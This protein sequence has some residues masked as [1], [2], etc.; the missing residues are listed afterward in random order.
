MS[1]EISKIFDYYQE[2]INEAIFSLLANKI[3]SGLA[4]LGIVIGIASVIIMLSLGQS[5]QKSIQSQ[6]Q[7]LGSNLL[8]ISPGATTSSGVRQAA[9]SSNTLILDDALA[10]K[11]KFLNNYITDVSPELSRRAQV[12]YERNNTNTQ[13]VGVYPGYQILRNIG[14]SEGDFISQFDVDGIKQVAVLGPQVVSDLFGDGVDPVGKTIRITGKSFRVIGVTTSKGGTGFFNQDD[15]IFVPLSTAQKILFGVDYLSSIAI[16]IKDEKLMNQARDEIGYF[17]LAR[18]KINNPYQADFTIMSQADILQT[19]TSVTSTFTNLLSGI[20][21]ISLLVGGIGIMNIMLVS[22][23]ERTREIGL[24][25]A[26]GAKNKIVVLQFLTESIILT[27]IGGIIGIISGVII[28][29]VLAKLMN[30]SFVLSWWGI[31]LSFI[32]SSIVG[33]VFGFYPAKKASELSPIEAL[34]YE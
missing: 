3:R 16:G 11:S 25:K 19:A 22:V 21:A 33:V 26:L 12:T 15:I 23:V 7:S 9:G 27:L 14:L 18:H 10:I 5:S 20:A 28:Y 4:I 32:F 29:F 8:T 1:N 34:R 24:R 31:L 30:F 13:I 2:I 17:L 6:I